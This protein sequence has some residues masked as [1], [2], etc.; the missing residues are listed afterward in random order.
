M[1]SPELDWLRGLPWPQITG[2]L[3]L[4]L[5]IV[6][7]ITLFFTALPN[8][9]I[10]ETGVFEAFDLKMADKYDRCAF[11]AIVSIVVGFVLQIVGIWLPTWL[12]Q[13]GV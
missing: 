10:R 13:A 4:A 3:G 2:T 8:K 6:G 9:A 7:V 11:W 5:D 1:S 12:R